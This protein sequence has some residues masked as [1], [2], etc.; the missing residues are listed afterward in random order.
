M[1]NLFCGK[2]ASRATRKTIGRTLILTGGSILNQ[3][4]Q[5][6]QPMTTP[7]QS[8]PRLWETVSVEKELPPQS[9]TD[10]YWLYNAHRDSK[11]CGEYD[12]DDKCFKDQTGCQLYGVTH[13]LRPIP[14][15]AITEE[16]LREVIGDAFD[17]CDKW[18]GYVTGA[19]L[20]EKR[21]TYVQNKIDEL[22]K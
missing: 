6:N 13:W 15:I 19:E 9:D 14:G 17:E 3:T 4:N 18:K 7:N 5:N 12:Y 8:T 20:E 10:Y 11:N 22:F 1:C 21:T 16:R 2:L